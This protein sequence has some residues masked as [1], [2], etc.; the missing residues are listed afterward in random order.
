MK[1]DKVVNRNVFFCIIIEMIWLFCIIDILMFFNCGCVFLG[2]KEIKL[3][4]SLD[5][6]FGFVM[7]ILY[8]G[9]REKRINEI[10]W[11]NEWK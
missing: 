2:S 7:C 3:V 11:W 8:L 1:V 9:D 10:V 6:V 4:F 5:I